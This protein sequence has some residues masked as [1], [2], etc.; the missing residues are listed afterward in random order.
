MLHHRI[1]SDK[2]RYYTEQDSGATVAELENGAIFK[3]SII[4]NVPDA[5]KH[6]AV[7]GCIYK[8]VAAIASGRHR[9]NFY[10]PAIAIGAALYFVDFYIYLT[11]HLPGKLG[12]TFCFFTGKGNKGYR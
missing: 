12:T 7:A 11:S 4:I 1:R 9:T 3:V 6:D 2:C 5:V 10:K 8:R